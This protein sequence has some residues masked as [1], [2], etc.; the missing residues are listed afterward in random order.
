MTGTH[1]ATHTVTARL[2]GGRYLVA[3]LDPNTEAEHSPLRRHL[4][5][6]AAERQQGPK[7]PET[8]NP[9]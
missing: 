5:T 3:I 7:G 4:R 8:R 1:G 9:N 2:P 6:E